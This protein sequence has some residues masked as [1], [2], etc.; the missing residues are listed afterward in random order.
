MNADLWVH[1]YEYSSSSDLLVNVRCVCKG[2]KF[3]LE[4]NAAKCTVWM[5]R[6]QK[7]IE[8]Y[9]QYRTLLV[10][11]PL[12]R[13]CIPSSVRFRVNW[14]KEFITISRHLVA[15]NVRYL[16]ISED[17]WY[18]NIRNAQDVR[19]RSRKWFQLTRSTLQENEWI[20]RDSCSVDLS[21]FT[22][23]SNHPSSLELSEMTF[24]VCT[25][26]RLWYFESSDTDPPFCGCCGEVI[27]PT[28]LAKFIAQ[29][30]RYVCSDECRN[31]LDQ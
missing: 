18:F 14:L 17:E 2:W 30:Q 1:V 27:G 21:R 29:V 31:K 10:Q 4:S 19:L 16:K 6:T 20:I 24:G 23:K 8:L 5:P 12:D 3:L 25:E 7:A 13:F 11:N 15:R 22:T 28:S 9:G 26:S